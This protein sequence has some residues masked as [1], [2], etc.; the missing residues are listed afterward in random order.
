MAYTEAL[1][2]AH[3]AGEHYMSPA[4]R[5]NRIKT[6]TTE[7]QLGCTNEQLPKGDILILWAHAFAGAR[8]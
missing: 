4:E 3:T 6:M 1:N 2:L 8:E 5:L 7:L